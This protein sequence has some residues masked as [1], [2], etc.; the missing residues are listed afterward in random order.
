MSE[1]EQKVNIIVPYGHSP[2]QP[3]READMKFVVEECLRPQTYQNTRIVLVESSKNPTQE[4]WVASWGGEY[5]YI[6]QGENPFSVGK[7]QNQ[8]FVQATPTDLYYFHQADFLLPKDAVEEAVFTMQETEA[9]CIFP[10]AGVAN[11]SK[12]LTDEILGRNV[13]PTLLI[14]ALSTIFGAEQLETVGGSQS[15]NQIRLSAEQLKML[16]SIL[17]DSLQSS[18]LMSDDVTADGN[19][20]HSLYFDGHQSEYPTQLYAD[21]RLGPRAKA[22]YL[23][24]GSAYAQLGGVPEYKGW[25]YEDL[26]FW[27]RV[28]TL[29][30]YSQTE[31]SI[32]FKDRK[33]TG[34]YPLVHMWHPTSGGENYYSASESNR[35]SHEA[36][37]ALDN[38]Q[39][40]EQIKELSRVHIEEEIE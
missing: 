39:R 21:F 28:K 19:S 37:M 22:S 38:E 20:S 10:Y 9:P 2:S 35:D 25:G 12:K 4:S 27:E 23:C 31:E 33:L 15:A 1:F 14:D 29:F 34:R 13:D 36:F 3:E 17:P 18:H 5:D 26:D 24:S 7:V 11:L 30:D 40:R 6:P 32:Y 16:E 8:G